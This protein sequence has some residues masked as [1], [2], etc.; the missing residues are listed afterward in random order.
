MYEDSNDSN[1]DISSDACFYRYSTFTK[2]KLDELIKNL[3]KKGNKFPEL[4]M[5]AKHFLLF[6]TSQ[7]EASKNIIINKNKDKNNID[8]LLIIQ[9]AKEN[10]IPFTG[11]TTMDRYSFY[12]KDD[13]LFFPFFC[14][15]VTKI[16]KDNNN[17]FNV[18]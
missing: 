15:E 14:F 17:N 5:Y 6:Y 4:I 2:N 16:E 13:I 10:L 3:S 1:L 18:Y 7:T 12:P 11:Y 9:N 8:V